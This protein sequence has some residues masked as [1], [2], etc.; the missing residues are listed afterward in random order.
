[1]KQ[2]ERLSKKFDELDDNAKEENLS[3]ARYLLSLMY[4][5][6]EKAYFDKNGIMIA[7]NDSTG[8]EKLF[9]INA[10]TLSPVQSDGDLEN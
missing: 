2:V 9:M 7:S 3:M 4:H 6:I 5:G 8:E 10:Y 1:M